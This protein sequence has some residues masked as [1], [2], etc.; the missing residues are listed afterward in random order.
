MRRRWLLTG[1]AVF[2]GLL[3]CAALGFLLFFGRFGEWAVRSKAIPR[4]AASLDREVEVEVIDV[5]R[6]RVVLSG[7]VIR[8]ERDGE[9]PLVRIPRVVVD[10]DFWAAV[11]G[12]LVI[13]RAVLEGLQVQLSRRADGTDNVRDLLDRLLGRGGD[14]EHPGARPGS[15]LRPEVTRVVDG[16]VEIRDEVLGFTAFAEDLRALVE[17]GRASAEVG[18][19]ALF[20]GRGRNATL[21]GA[22]V[23]VDLA[24]PLGSAVLGVAGGEI[25]LW[26]GMTLTGI[27]GQIARGDEPR[28]LRIDLSGGYGGVE[29]TL[30]RAR[31]WV[32][33]LAQTGRVRLGADRFTFDRIA[34]VLE[35]TVLRDYHETSMNVE[36]VVDLSPE[37]VDVKGDIAL[38]RLTVDSWRLASRPIRDLSLTGHLD[39]SLDRSARVLA[40]KEAR[41]QTG[42]VEYRVEGSAVLT[43]GAASEDET[44]REHPSL[45]A[46]LVIPPVPCQTVLESLPTDFAPYLRG[47]E[48]KGTFATDLTVEIDWADLEATVLDG[49][50]GIFG[51]EVVK[52]PE[53][54]SAR[55]L[56]GSFEVEV[57]VDG[58]GKEWMT[59]HIGP[60]SPDFVPLWDVSEHVA[61]AFMTREDSGFRS[62]KGFI[63]RE[64]RTALIRNLEHGRRHDKPIV[65]RFGA[66]SITM[67]TMKNVF[68]HREKTLSRKFQ[69]LFLT[70][71]VETQLTKDRILEIY[72][73]V[74]EYGPGLYGLKPAAETYFGKH[75]RYLNPVEASFLASLLPA[76]RRHY[77]Q[78]CRDELTRATERKLT[79]TIE[80]M[81]QRNR[82]TEEDYMGALLTPLGFSSH[83]SRLCHRRRARR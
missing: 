27:A 59:V 42:G 72:V 70:W 66:S 17:D 50:V 55:R 16:R 81:Y 33:P 1:G 44:S 56:R 20:S 23:S 13:E 36:V 15:G 5:A 57:P 34:S 58:A 37:R 14:D 54:L 82:L 47:F 31:G 76:P 38:D 63:V 80:L 2:L 39:A 6:G 12:D 73:N 18:D 61:R 9:H 43:G 52:A 8:G 25:R 3:V 77:L 79:Q 65:F 78:F 19:V 51:C 74:I 35:N 71:Y 67:Q 46:R 40:V 32:D 4:L 29:G 11:G 64:F 45:K 62:H 41:L 30:W 83:K 7:V 10:Y 48:L 22:T 26:E 21:G 53:A 28:A 69:E 68:L 60:E 24:D 49:S 75:P